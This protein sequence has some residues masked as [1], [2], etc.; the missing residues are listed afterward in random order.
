[1]HLQVGKKLATALLALANAG[2]N[3]DTLHLV[4]HSLG[5][6]LL[7]VAGKEVRSD[8]GP[9]IRRYVGKLLVHAA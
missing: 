2:L 1:M 4:G 9:R 6:Q 5:A 7:G 3:L 8:Q